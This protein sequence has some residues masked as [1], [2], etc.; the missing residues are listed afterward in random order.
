MVIDDPTSGVD[1]G[2]RQ[3]I[4]D[5]IR[6]QAA[7]GV[8]FIVCSSDP[9]DLSAVCDRILVLDEGEIVEELDGRR[10]RGVAPLDGD[11]AAASRRD[12][13]SED[14]SSR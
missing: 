1:I 6:H 4:Y 7:A 2:A 3:A 9:D 8:S 13:C 14:G 11:G 12:P 5:L 10:H